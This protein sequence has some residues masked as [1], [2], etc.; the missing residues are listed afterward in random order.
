MVNDFITIRL[1]DADTFES[2]INK[3]FQIASPHTF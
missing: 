2:H 1:P 3:S